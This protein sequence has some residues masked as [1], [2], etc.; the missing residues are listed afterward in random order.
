ME[1]DMKTIPY[2]ERLMETLS[3]LN[4][5]PMKTYKEENLTELDKS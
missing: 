4:P 1:E 3:P 2:Y 5:Q